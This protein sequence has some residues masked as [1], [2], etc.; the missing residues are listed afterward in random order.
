LTILGGGGGGGGNSAKRAKPEPQSN[1]I[2]TYFTPG[3]KTE[4]EPMDE[5]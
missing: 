5:D 1:T 3:P 2:F 4:P